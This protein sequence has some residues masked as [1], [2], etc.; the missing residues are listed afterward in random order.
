MELGIVRRL[1]RRRHTRRPVRVTTG[2]RHPRPPPRARHGAAT[3]GRSRRRYAVSSSRA[4]PARPGVVRRRSRRPRGEAAELGFADLATACF[5]VELVG[6]SAELV[7][8]LRVPLGAALAFGERLERRPEGWQLVPGMEPPTVLHAGSFDR[9]WSGRVHA[10]RAD[11][12]GQITALLASRQC[13]QNRARSSRRSSTRRS[14]R[15]SLR[16]LDG[17]DT[18]ASR[19]ARTVLPAADGPAPTR[20]RRTS[21]SASRRRVRC[22][23]KSAPAST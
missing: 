17:V 22:R 4:G 19:P 5:G 20:R 1:G 11:G 12:S 10:F 15:G 16:A 14:S 2:R 9:W 23:S 6:A 8:V 7:G 18:T 21:R 3:S 13:R